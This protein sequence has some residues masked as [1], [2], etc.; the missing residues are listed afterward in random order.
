MQDKVKMKHEESTVDLLHLF[1]Q[2]WRVK[3]FIIASALFGA[4][5]AFVIS[6]FFMTP[7]Y[8]SMTK[9]YI[10]NQSSENSSITTQD[11]Q[12]GN[13]LIKD[14]LEIILSRSVLQEVGNA[15]DLSVHQIQKK[16]EIYTPRDNRIL[17]IVITDSDPVRAARMAN[18]VREKSIERIKKIAKIQDITT[19]DAALVATEPSTP[20]VNKNTLYGLL[21]GGSLA[22]LFFIGKELLDDRICYPEDVESLLGVSLLGV[23][24][25]N[26][27]KRK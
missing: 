26:E 27:M 13:L 2:V 21:I 9:M 11:L 7:Q 25:Q 16:L 6:S 1:H 18:L 19:I 15:L 10:V 20:N 24:P 22:L 23:I 14:Y 8:R 5:I 3:F 12:L 4:V 17:T